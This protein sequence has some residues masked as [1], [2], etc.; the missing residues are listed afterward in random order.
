MTSNGSW[1]KV[2]F[3]EICKNISDRIDDPKQAKTDYYV[4][5]E[6]LDSEDPKIS[7]HG[8]PQD[9]SK[10]K[11]LFKPGHILFGKRNWYLRRL[12]VAQRDGICSAHMLVLEPIEGK[13][14][15]EFLP[16][17]MFSD[18]FYEKALMVSA[19]SMSPTIKWKDLAPLEFLIPSIT[20]QE[21]ILSIT[22]KIDHTISNSQNLLEK[23]KNYM[24]SRR[25]LLLTRGIGH[26]KFK[27]APWYYGKTIEIPEDWETC[28][29]KDILVN[30]NSGFHTNNF[31]EDGTNIV[32]VVDFYTNTKIDGQIFRFVELSQKDKNEY[33]LQKNDLLFVERSLVFSGIGKTLIVT[34]KGEG[35][36]FGGNIRRFS[37]NTK[38]N[39]QFLYFLLETA[40]LRKS[41]IS[42]SFVS[43]IT[44]ITSKEYFQ[45]KIFIPPLP[46]QQ[47]IISILSNINEQI[48]QQ[49]SHLNNLKVL[50][51]SILNSKLTKEKTNVTN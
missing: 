3:D 42:R 45:T 11:L 16:L 32:G 39:A 12:A 33:S 22:H 7:R 5:L 31:K 1:Q 10:T 46:E 9:V 34:K 36:C 49:Q 37:V 2:R 38:C 8:S 40:L 47:K 29:I 18:D 6:H 27:K 28:T 26:T 4:G 35:T 43:T 20:E 13:S 41:I 14:T 19:G 48:T 44:G 51:K 50:R 15:K 24:I 17:L 21:E 30:Q 25:E 23:T